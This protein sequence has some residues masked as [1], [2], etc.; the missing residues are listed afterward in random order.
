MSRARQSAPNSMENTNASGVTNAHEK[1]QVPS[2]GSG[3]L[4][5][6]YERDYNYSD[7]KHVTRDPEGNPFGMTN[8]MQ[9]RVRKALSCVLMVAERARQ[10]PESRRKME[11]KYTS[12]AIAALNE[13]VPTFNPMTEKRRKILEAASPNI[14]SQP[15]PPRT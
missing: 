7:P 11:W 3:P 4:L 6:G 13:L 1:G 9:W 14:A 2:V 5:G 8:E 15:T 10:T 12:K